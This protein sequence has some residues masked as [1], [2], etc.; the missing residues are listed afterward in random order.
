MIVDEL[1]RGLGENVTISILDK[2]G[3]LQMWS[4]DHNSMIYLSMQVM[5]NVSLSWRE[6][7]LFIEH[8]QD[9][10][11]IK[12][13]RGRGMRFPLAEGGHGGKR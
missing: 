3:T 10:D 11:L 7:L 12:L 9:V 6:N 5:I 13:E 8:D 2:G 4:N 1:G